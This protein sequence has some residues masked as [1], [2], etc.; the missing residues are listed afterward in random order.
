MRV[1]IVRELQQ[2]HECLLLG[3]QLV[4]TLSSCFTLRRFYVNSRFMPGKTWINYEMNKF[5]FLFESGHWSRS[6][7]LIEVWLKF[8]S[9]WRNPILIY[10]KTGSSQSSPRFQFVP[11]KENLRRNFFESGEFLFKKISPESFV[12]C[13]AA[14]LKLEKKW[15]E[16]LS[17]KAFHESSGNIIPIMFV[18]CV[19]TSTR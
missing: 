5:H 6:F 18:A 10:Y 9:F 8:K 2:V 16:N 7:V 4:K 14:Q 19:A 17:K 3:D 15:G 11:I 12:D 13:E 1:D